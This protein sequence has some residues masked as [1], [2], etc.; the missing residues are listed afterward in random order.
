MLDLINTIVRMDLHHVFVMSGV[1][2]IQLQ[3]GHQKL[4]C[5]QEIF[6]HLYALP[7]SWYGYRVI[8]YKRSACAFGWLVNTG[9]QFVGKRAIEETFKTTAI[10]VQEM[11]FRDTQTLSLLYGSLQSLIC[12]IRSVFSLFG[13]SSVLCRRKS[14]QCEVKCIQLRLRPALIVRSYF[15]LSLFSSLHWIHKLLCA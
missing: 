1:L 8:Y 14:L 13:L 11:S 15:Q 10:R 5:F 9:H 4:D 2:C 7:N 6:L 12:S 3:Y